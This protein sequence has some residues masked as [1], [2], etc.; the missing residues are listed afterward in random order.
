MRD[1][2][3]APTASRQRFTRL[4]ALPI[5]RAAAGAAMTAWGSKRLRRVHS[6]AA[7]STRRA[8]PRTL[9]PERESPSILFNLYHGA[10]PESVAFYPHHAPQE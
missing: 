5:G 6:G 4:A 1:R 2:S 10:N 9:F 3:S 7:P 8:T